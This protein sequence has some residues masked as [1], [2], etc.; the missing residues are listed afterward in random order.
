MTR[1]GDS[2][3]ERMEEMLRGEGDPRDDLWKWLAAACVM[4]MLG[5]IGVLLAFRT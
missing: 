3:R 2:G 4:C 5:E 1:P